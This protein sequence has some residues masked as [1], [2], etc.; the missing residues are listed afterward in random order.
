[1][2]RCSVRGA[3]GNQVRGL[4]AQRMALVASV[5]CNGASHHSCISWSPSRDLTAS[6]PPVQIITSEELRHHLHM[7]CRDEV[8][9]RAY[10]R[11]LLTQIERRPVLAVSI[12]VV[13]H[14]SSLTAPLGYSTK[15]VGDTTTN[16]R[17]LK[18]S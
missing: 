13:L 12:E 8:G 5:W 17:R 15:L 9:C 18:Q 2:L 1:M 11:R 10:L 3:F 4:L 16:G 7:G 14:C 6:A